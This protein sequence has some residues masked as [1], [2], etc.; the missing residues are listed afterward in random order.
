MAPSR[1]TGAGQLLATD[2]ADA[3]FNPSANTHI[4]H[5]SSNTWTA[6]PTMLGVHAGHAQ[7]TLPDGRVF[8]YSGLLTG[9]TVGTTSELLSVPPCATPTTGP[10]SP[11]ATT[12]PGATATPTVCASGPGT[13]TD[14]THFPT[15]R[16]R[17]VAVNFGTNIY[18][19][20]GRPDNT[21][22]TQDIYQYD[23]TADSWTLLP[24]QFPDS[25][26]PTWA[27]AC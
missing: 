26:P 21:T 19:F 16:G 23:L 10:A 6:G 1:P 15:T 14:V 25:C 4:Y 20:G 3:T 8:V 11:T 7:A 27:A 12:G 9:T 22:Y 5:I 2:G 13:W 18:I 24:Q 17:A